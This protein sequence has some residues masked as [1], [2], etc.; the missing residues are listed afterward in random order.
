LVVRSIR[1][2]EYVPAS[3]GQMYGA[4]RIGEPRMRKPKPIQTPM[5]RRPRRMTD[6]PNAAVGG[7][8]TMPDNGSSR[9]WRN[10]PVFAFALAAAP[11]AEESQRLRQSA[12]AARSDKRVA[13]AGNDTAHP[14]RERHR[15]PGRAGGEPVSLVG[16]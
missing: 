13:G 16:S 1:Q 9:P 12:G 7:S 2:A 3:Y 5:G 15:D 14:E 11:G 8:A 10:G 4:L 6:A